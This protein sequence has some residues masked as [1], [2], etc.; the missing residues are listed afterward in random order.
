MSEPVKVSG[1][2][3]SAMPIGEYD[4]RIVLLTSDRGKINGFAR[5]ARR[6]GSSMMAAAQPFV[7]GEFMLYEG[8]NSY[9]FVSAGSAE[10]FDELRKD[11]SAVCY[12][13]YFLELADYYSRENEDDSQILALLYL[14]VKALIRKQVPY[15]LIRCIFELRILVINGE[16][17]D[18][19]RCLH[20]GREDELSAFSAAAHG[21]FCSEHASMAGASAVYMNSAAVYAAQYIVS[22][23]LTRLFA[24]TVSDEVQRQLR[25]MLD[26][27]IRTVTDRNFRSLETLK[28][29]DESGS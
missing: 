5:G 8:R 6:P 7:Y 26:S 2:V 29:I 18:F 28:M 17:P 12:G 27:Y 11:I 1:M 10:Y 19:F 4:R 13:S 23:P 25:G 22:K 16:Y 9:T 14:S 20:C 24:F 21:M 15:P 3:L